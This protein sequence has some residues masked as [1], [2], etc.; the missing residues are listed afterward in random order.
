LDIEGATVET[1]ITARVN[2]REIQV[3]ELITFRST[4]TLP[5]RYCRRTIKKRRNLWI[6]IRR[7]TYSRYSTATKLY[8]GYWVWLYWNLRRMQK[9]ATMYQEIQ[10]S[11]GYYLKL[12]RLGRERGVTPEQIMKLIQM[13]D[14]IHN[15]Q[16]KLQQLQ[17]DIIEIGMRKSLSKEG[18]KTLQDEIETTREKLT[19]VDKAFKIKY[20]ELKETCSQIQKLENYLEK[21]KGGQDYQELEDIVRNEVGKTLL[22]NKK[23]L[24][25]ALVSV[26]VAL[27]NDPDR[28]L[29]IDRM[30]LTPFTTNTIINYDSFLALRRGPPCPQGDE[31]FVSGRVLEMAEKVLGNLQ[32]GIVD[33]TISTAAGLEEGSSY[34]ATNRAL[35]YYESS[36]HLPTYLNQNLER[37]RTD[38]EEISN[39]Y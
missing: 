11:M 8:L 20:E 31:Q 6:I 33:N 25:N 7:T 35:P 14:S 38:T 17:S 28:H 10:D 21:L 16:E 4:P 24:Q 3:R 36:S 2:K 37:L 26:V 13:A 18:L 34:S 22:D 23:L 30:E 9:L 15:L 27:R 5:M 12:F 32:K 1:S 29:L 39:N 19:L